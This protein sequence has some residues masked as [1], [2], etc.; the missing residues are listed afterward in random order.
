MVRR[1]HR[2]AK[3][4]HERRLDSGTGSIE[5]S[6]GGTTVITANPATNA[7]IITEGLSISRTLAI[8]ATTGATVTVSGII[9]GGSSTFTKNGDGTLVLTGANT[10]TLATNLNAGTLSFANGT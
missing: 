2:P 1:R 9:S 5:T 8:N 10:Y 7:N 4:R 6:F 3:H